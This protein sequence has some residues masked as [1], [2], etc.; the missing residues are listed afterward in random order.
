MSSIDK[1]PLKAIGGNVREEE[2][3]TPEVKSAKRTVEI[4]ET[5]ARIKPLTRNSEIQFAWDFAHSH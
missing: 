3:Q 1:T 2:N 5:L 4:L